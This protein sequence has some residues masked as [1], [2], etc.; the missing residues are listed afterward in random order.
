MSTQTPSTQE[1]YD[2]L[3]LG[4]NRP[5]FAIF[6]NS[7]KETVLQA[8]RELH[9]NAFQTMTVEDVWTCHPVRQTATTQG[10]NLCFSSHLISSLLFSSLFFLAYEKKG[11]ENLKSLLSGTGMEVDKE[12]AFII[13]RHYGEWLRGLESPDSA[14][15]LVE[16][17]SRHYH[18]STQARIAKNN[19]ILLDGI[20]L[21]SDSDSAELY[22]AF[23]LNNNQPKIVKFGVNVAREF[24][25][26]KKLNISCE[27]SLMNYLAPIEEHIIDDNGK[28]G[29]VMPVFACSL[30]CFNVD[31]KADPRLL[32]APV[33]QGITQI[34]H[35]LTVLHKHNITHNDI[36]PSNIFVDFNGAWYL[37]DWGSCYFEGLSEKK[38]QYTVSFAPTDFAKNGIKR[39]SRNFD[40]LLLVVT[41]LVVLGLLDFTH[42]FNIQTMNEEIERIQLPE[43]KNL[44]HSLI[45]VNK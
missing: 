10:I 39:N 1:Q 13:Q 3:P 36:K 18:Q 38:F 37:G 41:A 42:E 35:A 22:R 15:A 32:E 28:S 8:C 7:S 6:G 45:A 2:A 19:S 40:Q 31:R 27:D 11:L 30:S 20:L 26:F 16:T 43:L 5:S 33:L 23:R 29:L 44:L 9:L 17:A 21:Q 34:A 4:T 14:I 25:C 24:E 12:T